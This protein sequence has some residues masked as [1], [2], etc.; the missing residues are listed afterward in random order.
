VNELP[1]V[2]FVLPG[3]V[4]DPAAA[5]G[6]NL[7]GRRMCEQ[8]RAAKVAVPGAWPLGDPAALSGSLAALPDGAVVVIDGLVACAWPEVVGPAARRLR[9]AVLVHLPLGDEAGRDPAVAADLDTRERATLHAA[10]AVVATSPWSARR[11]IEHHELDPRRVHVVSPGTA[12]APLATGTDGRSRL[13]CVAAVTRHKGQDLLVEALAQVADLPWTCVCAG[14][15]RRE[16]AFA[17]R[18]RGL[19]DQHGLAGRVLLVGPLSGDA[20]EAGYAAADLVVLASR[21]ETYGM[22]V[23]EALMRGIPVLATAA[24]AVPDT[25]GRGPDGTVPGILV[26]ERDPAAFAA[27]LRRWLTEPELP[28]QLRA[29]ARRRRSTL[30]GWPAAA[31]KLAAVLDHVESPWAA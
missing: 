20:L 8:L 29:S 21:A 12:S 25:L 5:S 16:P 3:D 27:A 7:Y 26:S 17:D 4:D 15:L 1:R 23:A 2:T 6:G 10:G 28:D 19:I 11:L 9:L 22:V 30:P 18:V 13:L 14:P 31:R 24:G